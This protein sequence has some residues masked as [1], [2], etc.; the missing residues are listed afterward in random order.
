MG[1]PYPSPSFIADLKQSLIAHAGR[2]IDVETMR[3]ANTHGMSMY[4]VV[5]AAQHCRIFQGNDQAADN[6][7]RAQEQIL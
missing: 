6:L 2:L 3:L 5:H 1:F 7:R 4:E